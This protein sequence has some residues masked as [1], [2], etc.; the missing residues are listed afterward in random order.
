MINNIKNK[1]TTR[2]STI[3]KIR[4]IVSDLDQQ[5][6]KESTIFQNKMIDVVYYLFNSLGISSKPNRLMLSKWVKL[7]EERFNEILNTVTKAKDEGLKTSADRRE[8]TLDNTER[9]LKD[10]GNGILTF[11]K[12]CTNIVDDVE[13]ILKTPRLTRS[14][15]KVLKILLLLKEIV[16]GFLYEESG[17]T[18]MHKLESGKSAAER[19]NQQVRGLKILTPDQMLNRLPILLA[20]L[21]AGNN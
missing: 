1:K 6:Q 3:K 8:I 20:Q 11:R 16:D 9:L 19:K 17:T 10:L 7:S 15:N 14:Q 4:D 5:R 2:K 18:N 21:K 13:S 12:K